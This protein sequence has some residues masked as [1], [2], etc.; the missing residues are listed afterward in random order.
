MGGIIGGVARKPSPLRENGS[1][2][3]NTSGQAR[4]ERRPDYEW[5][6]MSVENHQVQHIQ[7]WQE[8]RVTWRDAHA[9][10]SGWH[11]VDEYEPEEAT[12]VTVGCYWPNCQEHYLTLAGTIFQHDGDTPKTVGDINHIPWGWILKIEVI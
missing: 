8:I 1:G 12:A 7:P 6:F 9:P 5:S 11:E 10:H 3:A 2:L 4:Q